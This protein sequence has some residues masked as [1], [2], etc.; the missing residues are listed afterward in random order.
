V[1]I[2]FVQG[3]NGT[4]LQIMNKVVKDFRMHLVFF[5]KPL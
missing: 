2:M 3:V 5:R 1:V 4:L